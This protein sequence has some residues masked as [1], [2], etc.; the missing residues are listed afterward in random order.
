[1]PLD[2]LELG[3]GWLLLVWKE[4]TY[5]LERNFLQERGVRLRRRGKC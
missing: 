2:G 3:L 5:G 1:L 4:R